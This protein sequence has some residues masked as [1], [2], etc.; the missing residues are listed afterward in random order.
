MTFLIRGKVR[1]STPATHAVV[2][3]LPVQW[4]PETLTKGV[5]DA[6]SPSHSLLSLNGG[7]H[8]GRVLESDGSFTQRIADREEVDKPSRAVISQE[9]ELPT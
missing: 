9:S 5:V 1:L 6:N 8:L 3:R 7:K 4:R 2:R